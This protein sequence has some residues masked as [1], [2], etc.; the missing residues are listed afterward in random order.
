[1]VSFLSYIFAARSFYAKKLRFVKRNWVVFAKTFLNHLWGTWN[2]I[3]NYAFRLKLVGKFTVHFPLVI[4]EP[5]FEFLMSPC[6][7]RCFWRTESLQAEIL[8]WWVWR[9]TLLD[10]TDKCFYDNSASQTFHI[11]KSSS[12]CF[13]STE[14]QI[15]FQ[16]MVNFVVL[17][18][19]WG[20]RSSAKTRCR[21]PIS[22]NWTFF[23]IIFMAETLSAKRCR[24]WSFLTGMVTVSQNFVFNVIHILL[25][26]QLSA[27]HTTTAIMA[28][29][30]QSFAG[31]FPLNGDDFVRIRLYSTAS[32]CAIDTVQNSVQSAARFQQYIQSYNIRHFYL[33]FD[34]AVL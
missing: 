2:N 20:L 4:M 27:S 6:R 15:Y 5:L 11:K 12:R 30:L 25:L 14:I 13:F 9:I 34:G 24:S 26:S 21:P 3:R 16:K 23:A 19:L 10:T 32:H 7:S 29:I 17:A 31:S 8:G 33:L 22:K 1:M 18:I 28:D